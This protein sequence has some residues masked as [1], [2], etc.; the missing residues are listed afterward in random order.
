MMVSELS[1]ITEG[2]DLKVVIHSSREMSAQW[3]VAASK[4][5][6]IL[7]IILKN[8]GAS[9]SLNTVCRSSPFISKK[10]TIEL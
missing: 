9:H 3:L 7:Q 5:N 10:D 1:G 2:Q 8:H 4:E 6:Q